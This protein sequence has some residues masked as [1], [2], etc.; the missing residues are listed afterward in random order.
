MPV[1]SV[2]VIHSDGQ[3]ATLAEIEAGAIEIALRHT[4]SRTEAAKVLGLGRS[5]LY[6]KL[7]EFGLEDVPSLPSVEGP[8]EPRK[9]PHASA[10]N[11]VPDREPC[12]ASMQGQIIPYTGPLRKA[13]GCDPRFERNL[14]LTA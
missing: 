10:P 5:T 14:R 4:S 2:P 3:F 9:K 11:P 13:V 12:P 1:K 7:L 6:R 8:R